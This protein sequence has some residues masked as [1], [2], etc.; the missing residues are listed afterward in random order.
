MTPQ[1][2]IVTPTF[3]R[4]HLL[5]RVWN[6]LSTQTLQD[7]QW[8]VVDDGS[9]DNTR[10]VVAGFQDSRITYIQ[11]DNQGCNAA[12]N[13]GDREVRAEFVVYL[14]SDDELYAPTTLQEM[15]DAIRATT[16]EVAWVAFTVVDADSC[17]V[18][19][20]IDGPSLRAGY[21]DVV[22]EQRVKGD[23]LTI[24][25]RDALRISAWPPFPGGEVIRHF[26]IAKQRPVIYMNRPALVV[27][28][29][30]GDNLVSVQSVVK[31]ASPMA[32]AMA[33]LIAEHH[34]AWRE[35]CPCQL[36]RYHFVHALY[37]ALSVAGYRS[38]S[39]VWQALRWG[40]RSTRCK[41]LVLALSTL[42]PLPVRQWLFILRGA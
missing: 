26:R 17:T 15:V 38:W 23:F 24:C 27:H 32:E 2:S 33:V 10:E 1:V 25:R 21:V 18:S 16:P 4:A 36:G 12:R 30:S 34:E 13:R 7:F 28:R 19:S 40:D 20:F 37:L 22:C 42:L 11:Q 41:A 35:H 14:D 9:S 39:D 8:I 5:P 6:S 31:R 3:N 29:G